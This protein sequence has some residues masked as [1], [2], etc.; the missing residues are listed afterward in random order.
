MATAAPS[1]AIAS[2]APTE[3][4]AAPPRAVWPPAAAW[5]VRSWLGAA[6]LAG[7]LLGAFARLLEAVGIPLDG[8]DLGVVDEAIDQGDDA[9]G[10]GENLAPF[11]ER[12]VGGDQRAP[13]LVAA[14]DQLEHQ[15]GVAVG[16][17]EI[18]DL[19]DHQQLG[20][21]IMAQAPAQSGI[22]VERAKIT[23]QLTGA[24]EQHGTAGDQRLMRDILRQRRLADAIGA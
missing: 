5:S 22:A 21:G 1:A 24:G 7:A 15:V 4:W 19:V 6:A 8:D 13:D 18:A 3:P 17:G 23:E 16:V 12:A 20:P 11:G 10:V 2:A 9:G 14:R